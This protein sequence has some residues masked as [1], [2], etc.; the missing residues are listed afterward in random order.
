M[1]QKYDLF[2]PKDLVHGPLVKDDDGRYY[3]VTEVDAEIAALKDRIKELEGA[4]EKGGG[5]CR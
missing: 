3:L 2:H 4:L 1:M 5:S